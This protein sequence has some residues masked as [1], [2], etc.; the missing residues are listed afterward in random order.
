[1]SLEIQSNPVTSSSLRQ[2][3]R[4]SMENLR[5]F[6]KFLK[7]FTQ[8]RENSCYIVTEDHHD[9]LQLGDVLQHGLSSL[10]GHYLD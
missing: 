6:K 5:R 9:Y 10:A 3:A 1:M 8:T 2:T 4:L 7:C